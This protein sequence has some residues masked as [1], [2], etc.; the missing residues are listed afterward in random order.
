MRKVEF[1][2]EWLRETGEVLGRMT[3]CHDGLC[4]HSAGES[5]TAQEQARGP[6]KRHGMRRMSERGRGYS[7]VGQC[8][9][10]V[11]VECEIGSSQA[12]VLTSVP[13]G[14]ERREFMTAR[15]DGG[16]SRGGC[17]VCWPLMRCRCRLFWLAQ[18]G[19]G[20]WQVAGNPVATSPP[21]IH[22]PHVRGAFRIHARACFRGRDEIQ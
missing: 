19:G 8:A 2:S 10:G 22:H 12:S 14:A 7:D 18:P 5:D 4:N 16:R 20:G 21:P 11:D 1:C 6:E 15:C 9:R 3:V 13:G 17:V